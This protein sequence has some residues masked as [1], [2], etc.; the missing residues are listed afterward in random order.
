MVWNAV[1][2]RCGTARSRS[3]DQFE[4]FAAGS[5]IAAEQVVDHDGLA[6]SMRPSYSAGLQ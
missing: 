2:G 6:W 3:R 1:G 4:F 5:G